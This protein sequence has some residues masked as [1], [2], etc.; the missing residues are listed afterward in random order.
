MS[1]PVDRSQTR[2][3]ERSGKPDGPAPSVPTLQISPQRKCQARRI[4]IRR[5]FSS[6]ARFGELRFVASAYITL[7]LCNPVRYTGKGTPSSG[8]GV[9]RHSAMPSRAHWR[10][11][12]DGAW[13]GLAVVSSGPV[14]L[15]GCSCGAGRG[16]VLADPLRSVRSACGV[17]GWRPRSARDW[18]GRPWPR[19]PGHAGVPAR[20][21][22]AGPG[23]GAG[24]AAGG[25]FGCCDPDVAG[26][27]SRCSR[28]AAGTTSLLLRVL[29]FLM[30]KRG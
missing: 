25:A 2:R 10:S 21:A 9:L 4:P 30:V 6:S 28:V 15:R 8:V 1:L 20:R 7:R 27:G 11:V 13:Q 22:G 29:T 17:R 3:Q 26:R 19:C 14:T 16:F 18:P 12:M 24:Q 5:T 23:G